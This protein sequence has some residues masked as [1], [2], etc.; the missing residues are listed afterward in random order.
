MRL[1]L[2]EDRICTDP[3]TEKATRDF[4]FDFLTLTFISFLSAA[5]QLATE[6]I[7][8]NESILKDY[9]LRLHA[10]DGQC[11]TDKVMKSFIDYIRLNTFPHMAGILGK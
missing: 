4:Y 2:I 6:A 11:R 5:A 10:Y 8:R 1:V 7:N 9:S 3:T